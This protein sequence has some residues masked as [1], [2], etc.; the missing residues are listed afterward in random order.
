MTE[1]SLLSEVVVLSSEVVGAGLVWL[2]C[3]VIPEE[4]V[5]LEDV[6]DEVVKVEVVVGLS[7]VEEAVGQSGHPTPVTV[8]HNKLKKIKCMDIKKLQIVL[9]KC[10]HEYDSKN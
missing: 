2:V 8:L 6:E 5:V 4:N 10:Y 1:I 3:A 9:R 7:E